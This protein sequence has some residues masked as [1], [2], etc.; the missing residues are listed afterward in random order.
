MKKV[1]AEQKNSFT[2]DIPKS[3]HPPNPPSQRRK[4]TLLRNNKIVQKLF[5]INTPVHL[6]NFSFAY[7][8]LSF[9]TK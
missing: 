5:N 7:P 1:N 3:K 6:D 2:L 8:P 4:P 9:P